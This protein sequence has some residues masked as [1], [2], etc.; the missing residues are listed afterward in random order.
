MTLLGTLIGGRIAEFLKAKGYE[1]YRFANEIQVSANQ[2]SAWKS[3]RF[4][5]TYFYI[6]RL[7]KAGVDFSGIAGVPV[8]DVSPQELKGY[9]RQHKLS[10]KQFAIDNCMSPATVYAFLKNGTNISMDVMDAVCKAVYPELYPVEELEQEPMDVQEEIELP[11]AEDPIDL[12]MPDV[13]EERE[14]E[15]TMTEAEKIKAIFDEKFGPQ[16]EQEE[17]TPN[18]IIIPNSVPVKESAIPEA[19]LSSKILTIRD[20]LGIA[21]K[22]NIFDAKLQ[23]PGGRNIVGYSITIDDTDAST[24]SLKVQ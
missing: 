19:E 14:D 16:E 6:Q 7:K 1:S 20:L 23:T 2:L 10:V 22:Y 17:I 24:L 18:E 5:P 9:I 11:F 15:N 21:E 8:K 12:I 3:G 13:A 4:I